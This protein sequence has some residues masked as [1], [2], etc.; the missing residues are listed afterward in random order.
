MVPDKMS[1]LR[2]LIVDD[3]PTARQVLYDICSFFS[4]ETT[5][6]ASGQEALS[7]LEKAES[8]S[9]YDLILMDWK[10]TGMDG[11][12]TT[13]RIKENSK[14]SNIPVLLV[15][16]YGRDEVKLRAE[17]AG[18]EGFLTKPI[19]SSLLYDT[20]ME[21]FKEGTGVKSRV[22]EQLLETTEDL[23]PI[24][25]A[26]I[27]L[28]EDNAINQQVATELLEQAGFVVTV[29]N[30][31]REGVQ[32]VKTSEFD[33]VLM[34]IQMPEM[35]GH[36]ATRIIRKD[37]GFDSLPIV[38]LTAH[39]MAGEREKCLNTGMNDY[40]SKPIKTQ[41]LYAVL[42]KWIKPGDRSVPVSQG[43]PPT[44]ED[45]DELPVELPTSLPG[46]DINSGL[47]NVGGN[48]KLYKQLLQEFYTDYEE[49]A[50]KIKDS[51]AKGDIE[52][53]RRTAHTI[54]G[55]SGSIGA[56]DLQI[57]AGKLELAIMQ[58]KLESVEKLVENFE[59]SIDI[60]L[61][62]AY[63]LKEIQVVKTADELSH[64]Q[65]VPLDISKIEPLFTELDGLLSEGDSDAGECMLSIM[66]HLEGSIFQDKLK[67]LDDQINRFLFKDALKTLK[68]FAKSINISLERY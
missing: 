3:N 17:N 33:L 9:P 28:V 43:P 32:K 11:I 45:R 48:K 42:I 18:I 52:Y 67:L 41:E 35:D 1:G 46:I 68:E 19:S 16:G 8:D 53:V 62:S 50:A 24:K 39:A 49:T 22:P 31:G 44:K 55:I 57:E 12:E 7:E 21:L 63:T 10:M 2:V 60:V 38:A 20:I 15:T 56:E 23:K 61:Q 47:K 34:D 36:E 5:D 64:I 37:P 58:G 59:E 66:E 25:G 29:A 65:D 13:R 30:N 6:V 54:K 4:F 40:L 26:R 51:L 14:L 27:L